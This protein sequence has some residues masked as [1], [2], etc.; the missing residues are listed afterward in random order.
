MSWE[1][2]FILFLNCPSRPIFFDVLARNIW[3]KTRSKAAIDISLVYVGNI[4]IA[5]ADQEEIM[6]LK[7]YLARKFEIRDLGQ[8]GYFL[9]IEPLRWLVWR[10]SH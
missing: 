6:R 7:D 1:E 10:L 8:L 3:A 9:G 5:R 2:V 4:V